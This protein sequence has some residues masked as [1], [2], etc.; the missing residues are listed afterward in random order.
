MSERPWGWPTG[1]IPP[2]MPGPG[3]ITAEWAL[4]GASGKGIHV[5]IIDSGVDA[6]HPRLSGGVQH[7]V[8][9]EEGPDG[10]TVLES[11]HVD[12][13]GHGTACAGIIR[14]LAPE[15]EISSVR[16]LGP[17]LK[18]RGEVFIA[19]L[20]WALE[21][22]ARVCNLSLGT[23]RKEHAPDL[24]ALAD[25]AY[26]RNVALVTAANNMPVASFPSLFSAAISVA[27]HGD[28][29]AAGHY[30]N[31]NP[32]V[33]FGAP[34]MDIEVL[35]AGGGT[36]TATGNSYAAPYISGLSAA[37]LSAHPQLTVFE[38]KTVL[39]ALAKNVAGATA[40]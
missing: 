31:P 13:F 10:V 19:G 1:D 20:R 39:R 24:Y 18:G 28:G 21:H 32:P 11:R 5:A 7:W 33:E 17:R 15:C 38:L 22:G 34:G 26:F 2:G 8:T 35:W 27:A 36:L 12:L 29:A 9:V 16:V 40:S 4:G 37:I 23:T 14:S 25:E 6:D 3:E 30:Y